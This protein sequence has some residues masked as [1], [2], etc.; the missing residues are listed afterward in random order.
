M[1]AVMY[2]QRR[3][4][5][6]GY[7][8]GLRPRCRIARRRT[9]MSRAFKKSV[10]MILALVIILGVLA[11]PALAEETKVYTVLGDSNAAGYGLDA[12][13]ELALAYQGGAYYI[14]DGHR[15]S[16]CYADY[17]ASALG[18]DTV[19]NSYS[20]C[21]WRTDEFL[22]MIGENDA[23]AYFLT[24]ESY[25]GYAGFFLRNSLDF[26]N[27]NFNDDWKASIREAIKTA[28][29]ITIDFGSNDIFTYALYK[30]YLDHPDL[31]DKI[32]ELDMSDI[33]D[34]DSFVDKL[35]SALDFAGC[36]GQYMAEFEVNLAVNFERFKRNMPL[37]IEEVRKLNK[38]ADIYVLGMFNPADISYTTDNGTFLSLVS[39][40]DLRTAAVNAYLRFE[41]PALSEYTYVDVTFAETQS[42]SVLDLESNDIVNT[43]L[44]FVKMMHATDKGH[45]YIADQIISAFKD[46]HV[47]APEV[48]VRKSTVLKKNIL[49]WNKLDGAAMYRVYRSTSE[50]GDYQY[51]GSTCRTTFYDGLSLYSNYYYKVCAVMD[52]KNGI[53]SE[54]S[55]AVCAN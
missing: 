4:V 38:D 48:S 6:N 54:M 16:G 19:F 33:N 25:D 8:N 2:N 35:F 20:Y 15:I 21:G 43:A 45:A 41:C 52:Y 55:N 46:K 28:D 23:Y 53:V 37:V 32:Y 7:N 26:T 17:V 36:L 39:S 42:A 31:L 18:D 40:M 29:V 11:I 44:S 22:A 9:T 12:Y 51:I 1:L 24:D 13:T 34:F 10:S 5:A 14:E 50:D 30:I 3:K 27:I 47:S 49:S